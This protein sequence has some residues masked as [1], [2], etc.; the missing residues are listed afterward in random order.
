MGADRINITLSADADLVARARTYATANHTT[1]NQLIRDHM[2]QLTGG[3]SHEEAASEF[4]RV[5][6]ARP[7]RSPDAFRFSRDAAHDRQA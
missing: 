6:R 1:L 2:V 7:G 4:A 3:L 5:A